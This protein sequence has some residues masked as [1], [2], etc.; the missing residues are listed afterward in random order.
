MTAI[1]LNWSPP[2]FKLDT[3][4]FY[5]PFFMNKLHLKRFQNYNEKLYIVLCYL[6]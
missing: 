5:F 6:L 4:E 3:G 2:N 1:I